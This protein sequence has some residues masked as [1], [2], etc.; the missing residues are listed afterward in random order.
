MMPEKIG[1]AGANRFSPCH[2]FFPL[3]FQKR[4]NRRVETAR[5]QAK[6]PVGPLENVLHD[7]VP[8]PVTVSERDEDMERVPGKREK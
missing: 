8:V 2:N 5:T 1:P 4:T 3:L 7:R 6:C